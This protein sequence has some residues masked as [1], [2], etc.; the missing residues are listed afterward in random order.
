MT[1][2]FQL[3]LL[4]L[5]LVGEVFASIIIHQ[6]LETVLER[7]GPVV[8]AR[9]SAVAVERDTTWMSIKVRLERVSIL[10]GE[11]A[12][13][14]ESTYSYS[15][16]LERRM[17]DGSLK[18]LSPIRAGSGIELDLREG[19]E[20]IFLLEDSG[21]EFLRAEPLESESRIQTALRR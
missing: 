10:R 12:E 9:V 15:L 18:R 13:S 4:C 20:Y 11:C 1:R 2:V 3:T 21:E 16:L 5:L 7:G 17:A 14:F 8:R 6:K 19:E